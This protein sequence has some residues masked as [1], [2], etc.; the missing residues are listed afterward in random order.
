LEE[1][2]VQILECLGDTTLCKYRC[3]VADVRMAWASQAH[4]DHRKPGGR[5]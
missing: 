1:L 3:S 4:T 2:A 5:L